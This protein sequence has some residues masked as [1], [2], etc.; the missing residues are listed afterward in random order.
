M[1]KSSWRFLP[2]IYFVFEQFLYYFV[3]NN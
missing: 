2:Q 1:G 3:S